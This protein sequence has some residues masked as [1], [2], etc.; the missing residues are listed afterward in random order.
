M[1]TARC[2]AVVLAT[3]ALLA[4]CATQK[5]VAPARRPADVRAE[6]VRLM[7]AGAKDRSGWATDITAAFAALGVEPSTQNLC[8]SLAVIEQESTFSVDPAV[9]N[10][11]R[12]A[13][14]E[15]DRR[16]EQ[17][18]VPQ[19]LVRGALA[20]KSSNGKSY[21]DRIAAVRTERELSL[22][23]EDLIDRIPLGQRLFAG[24][25]PVR[26]GGPMQVSV[27]FAERHAREHPYP[28]ATQDSIRHELFSRR[29]GVYFGIAHLL[30]Y[31]AAYDR[32]IY[33]FADFNA[34][35]YASRNAAFQNA[36]VLASGIPLA[37]DGDL[38]DYEDDKPGA[39]ELAVRSLGKQIDFSD[40]QI[41]RALKRGE[42]ADFEKSTLYERVFAL[43]ERQERKPLPR[44]MMP[45][46]D[47]KSPKI[48]RKLTTEWFATRV[49][50]RY[51]TCLGKAGGGV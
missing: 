34:G 24:S 1:R 20:L 21:A 13:R 38:V 7:P 3:L 10:L 9:P 49:D 30:G 50:Q 16:A 48:T 23:Y 40:A 14:A 39:T 43:A 2:G 33:R 47:L 41:H 37:L 31:P 26:T 15:I 11:G 46:I 29:G 6:I 18:H 35:F 12:I 28:Y 45:R 17:H 8:A 44:A 25:N 32:M 27:A 51:R 4:G 36:V 42:E 19:L 22:V 5:P